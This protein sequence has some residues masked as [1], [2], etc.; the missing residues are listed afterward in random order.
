LLIQFTI[1]KLWL[2]RFTP[3]L[4]GLAAAAGVLLFA[5][6]ERLPLSAQRALSFLPVKVDS[7]VEY[8][9]EGSVEWRLAMWQVLIPEIPHYFLLGKGYSIDPEEIYFANI[10][11]GAGDPA[12][13]AEIVAGDYH[14]GPLSLIIPLG[15]WGVAGFFWLL[16]AGINVLYRNFRYGDPALRNINAFFLAYFLMESIVFFMVFGAF[17]NQLFMF[18]GILGMSVCLNGGAAK[19]PRVVAR[20]AGV[21]IVARSQSPVSVRV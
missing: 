11:G 20:A 1:E 5:F 14:S 13:Q 7:T 3:I 9:A 17:K 19:P 10:G 6:S 8:D 15:I 2:T 16:G 12:A 21:A 4:L 18:T